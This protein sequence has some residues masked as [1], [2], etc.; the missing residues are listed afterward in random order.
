MKTL[1]NWCELPTKIGIFR[2]YDTGDEQLRLVSYGDINEFK[3]RA[4]LVR[5]HSSCISSEIFNALD[6]DCS[7]QVLESMRMIYS[8]GGG[9]IIH[10]HDEGRGVGLSKKIAVVRLMQDENIDTVEA[11]DALDLEHDIRKYSKATDL[12]LKLGISQV[13]LITNNPA[14]VMYVEAAGITVVETVNTY[15]NVR[16]ENAEY[17]RS[18]NQKLH[19]NIPLDNESEM[20]Y[21]H[22]AELSYGFLSNFS[23]HP[24]YCKGVIW[25]TVEHYYQAQKF[26]D[27]KIQE[28]IRMTETPMMA[29]KIAHS[30]LKDIV[31]NWS[32]IKGGIMYDALYAKFTQHPDLNIQLIETNTRILTEHSFDD[33]YWGDGGDGSG[34]NRL[35]ILLMKIRDKLLNS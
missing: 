17:L 28:K 34:M 2:M 1:S 9:I 30:N 32:E 31:P 19:H 35:G 15:T 14:K 29:K 23:R 8:D 4:P 11:F 27:P 21:F 16:K 18:K 22:N 3:N 33:K 13:R 5:I 12:L 10:N 25:D 26:E 6:C 7:D 24:I 20:V